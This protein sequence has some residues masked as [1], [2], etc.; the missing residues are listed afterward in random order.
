MKYGVK[1]VVLRQFARSFTLLAL[2]LTPV[3]AYGEWGLG[4]AYNK[5]R[6][7]IGGN[8]LYFF[9]PLA[10]ELGVAG[11][12]ASSDSESLSNGVWGDVALKYLFSKFHSFEPFVE[13]GVSYGVGT[14][15][16]DGA[17]IGISFAKSTFLGLGL[18]FESGALFVSFGLDTTVKKSPKFCP[19]IMGGVKF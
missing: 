14:S 8:L 7:S 18:H 9:R 10:L 16:G 17:H 2:L 12:S 15:A 4:I 19:F 5:P 3:F 11:F 1:A 6:G 13:G